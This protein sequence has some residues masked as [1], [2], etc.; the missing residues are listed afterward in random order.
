MSSFAY[1]AC[2]CCGKEYKLD[3]W[4]Q[5]CSQCRGELEVRYK[6]AEP[7]AVR[8]EFLSRKRSRFI[9]QRYSCCLPFNFKRLNPA[10]SLGEGNTPLIRAAGSND[11]GIDIYYKNE[12]VNPTGSF[13]DRGTIAG[14][15]RAISLGVKKVGTVSTGN[16]AA[17]VA[18]YAARAGL[19]CFVFVSKNIKE[20]K[21]AS[22]IAYNP[23]LVKVE[24]DYGELYYRSLEL[25]M[26]EG[27]YFINSDDLFRVEGQK[28]AIYE[29]CEQLNFAAPDYI[30]LPVSS[31]GNMA[32]V[33]KGLEEMHAVG[34]I[35]SLPQVVGVQAAGC[36]PIAAS[37]AEGE[38]NIKRFQNPR[39]VAQ[40]IA[41]PCPPSGRRIL[42]KLLQGK[43]GFI[44]TVTD[45]Q[46]L[47]AQKRL[48]KEEGIFAQPAGA[49]PL[50]AL[51]KMVREGI[52]KKAEKVVA[53][54]SGS[55]LKDLSVINTAEAD[56]LESDFA[57]LRAIL[58]R[59]KGV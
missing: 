37:F 7:G 54:V 17:S 25:G 47:A 50:A 48:A 18:A 26:Q 44:L 1:I 51:E 27:V 49:A 29:I 45:A 35:D 10:L 5:R 59:G 28:T 21:L 16:M 46:I 11:L 34:L 31:G 14:I 13:K 58:I 23:T 2:T 57:G 56:I 36:R 8:K 33:I 4:Q 30:I 53:I 19:E 15:H 22:I 12:A 41:N 6:F 39:T 38:L 9:L 40:A 43:A 3:T 42:R 55:G 52:L 24:G 20:H 32:A